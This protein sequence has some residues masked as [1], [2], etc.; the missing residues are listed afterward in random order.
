MDGRE[1]LRRALD[2]H[3]IDFVLHGHKFL[4]IAVY[5]RPR[6]LF[7]AQINARWAPL[8]IGFLLN[9]RFLKHQNAQTEH[10]TDIKKSIAAGL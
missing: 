1:W 8:L 4:H 2:K 10:R 7:E 9:F 5:S 3:K 6:K